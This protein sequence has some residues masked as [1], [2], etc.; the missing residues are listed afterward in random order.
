MNSGRTG[1]S[2]ARPRN[3]RGAGHIPGLGSFSITTAHRQPEPSQHT[4]ISNIYGE[5]FKLVG[6][7]ISLDT[8]ESV[9]I[10]A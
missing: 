7:T 1:V 5:L 4:G 9:A 3:T 10:S 8:E 2:L 6:K